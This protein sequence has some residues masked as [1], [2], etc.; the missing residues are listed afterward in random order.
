MC[1]YDVCI[2][3]CKRMY[4]SI[5]RTHGCTLSMC[6]RLWACKGYVRVFA[7]VRDM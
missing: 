3:V 7:Y 5:R 1:M 6:S 4:M 2:G